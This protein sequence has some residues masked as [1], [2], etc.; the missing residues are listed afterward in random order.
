M[1]R[2][3]NV[4]TIAGSD[5]GGG[6]GIQA[7]L[8]AFS[9]A[10][11]YGCAVIT[12]LTAQNTCGVS[13]IH[14][15]PADFVA[16]QLDTLFEDIDIDAVKIGMI[17]TAAIAGTVADA[18]ARHAAGP[19]VL[20]PVMVA[21]GGDRLLDTAAVAVL[22]DRLLPM[23]AVITPNLPEAGVLLDRPAPEDAEGMAAAA[24][25]LAAFGP[26]AVLLKGGHLAGDTSPD[27]LWVDG[28]AHWLPGR[29]IDTPNT[30]GTGC[31]L[32]SAIAA[33]LPVAP[34]LVTA[35]RAA[36]LY[37]AGAI[38]HADRLSV[39]HGHGPTHH[40]HALWPEET[41]TS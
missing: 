25:A 16:R 9:A 20:D 10:G 19:I 23:A 2:I 18:L 30:H 21:K 29:R 26:R 15:P 34:D 35:V 39:G 5:P 7:D 12:A 3:P 13:G 22:R 33:R 24:E 37:V 11:A 14:L 41:A 31:T 1:T 38:A 4:L 17:A 28:A 32:S 27:L 8:K 6:A 40:F 36:K